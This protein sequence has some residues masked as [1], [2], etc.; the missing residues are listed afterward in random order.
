MS[1]TT[2]QKKR[3]EAIQIKLTGEMAKKYDVYYKVHSQNYG[4]LGWAKNGERAGTEGLALRMEGIQVQLV[5][6]GTKAPEGS[7]KAF[8]KK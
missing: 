8:I 3:M 4:W 1:G 7:Q 6:K 2:G 5:E